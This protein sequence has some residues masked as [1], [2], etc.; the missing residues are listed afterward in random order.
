MLK[1]IPLTI[2]IELDSLSMTVE[3]VVKFAF[4]VCPRD[5]KALAPP[6]FAFQTPSPDLPV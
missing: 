4:P 5:Q 1:T 2:Q 6:T 3:M